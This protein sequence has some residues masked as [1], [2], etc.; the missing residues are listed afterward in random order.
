MGQGRRAV[1]G[2]ALGDAGGGGGGA[3][4][5]SACSCPPINRRTTRPEVLKPAVGQ[6]EGQVPGGQA[7]VGERWRSPKLK[8]GGTGTAATTSS[9]SAI[10]ISSGAWLL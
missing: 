8:G 7:G 10:I 1:V 2:T 6:G 4:A 3:V 5:T 9:A